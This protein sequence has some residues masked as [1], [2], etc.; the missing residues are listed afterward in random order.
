M[1]LTYCTYEAK[2]H[3]SQHL[4]T[5]ALGLP[6]VMTSRGEAVAELRTINHEVDPFDQRVREWEAN[7]SV[8]PPTGAG[9]LP[10]W[11]AA[12]PPA[13]LGSQPASTGTLTRFLSER[14]ID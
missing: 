13:A 11:S 12:H 14:A 4:R 1:R 6:V 3:L 2:A 10:V 7:G 5:V 8:I 9:A